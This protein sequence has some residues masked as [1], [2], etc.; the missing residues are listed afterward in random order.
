MNTGDQPIESKNQLLS[1]AACDAN[2]SKQFALEGSIFIG[3]AVVQWLRDGLGLVKSADEIETLATSVEDCGGV[4]MVPAFAGLGA[5]HWDQ[6][7]RGTITG[8]TRGTT[9][10][11][12]CP[13][14]TGEH[15][16]SG[17]RCIGCDAPGQRHRHHRAPRLMVA[18]PP[19]TCCCSFRRICCAFR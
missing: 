11:H 16:V 10:A 18:R 9:A 1:T 6:Y 4:Y 13:R 19:M 17:C 14:G 5:P 12:F 2:G 15:R 8:I 7:A 3:G